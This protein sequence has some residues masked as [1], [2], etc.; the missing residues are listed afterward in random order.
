MFSSYRLTRVPHNPL[1]QAWSAADELA[2]SKLN[3]IN[4]ASRLIINE[5]FGALTTALSATQNQTIHYLNDSA[6]SLEAI[7]Q[8]LKANELPEQHQVE[9]N[10]LSGTFD[11]IILYP[12]K[13]IEYFKALLQLASRCLSPDGSLFIP[14]MVK[15]LAKG[16]I[17]A[18]NEF[19]AQVNPGRA[20]K[21]ARLV[22]IKQPLINKD[23]KSLS[24]TF[25]GMEVV[26]LPG[27]Y[28]AKALDQGARVF[29]KH[30]DM[31]DVSGSILDMGCGNGILSI[32]LLKRN[33]SA[34]LCL[35]DEHS[36][37]I[38]SAKLNIQHYFPAAHVDF[39]HSNGMNQLAEHKFNT[40][41]CNPPF[42]QENTVTEAISQKLFTDLA[43][44]LESK[45]V[46]WI[47]ANRHLDYRKKLLKLFRHVETPS[48]DAKF[49]LYR[50]RHD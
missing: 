29:I 47:I 3:E 50:C 31:I 25:D 46:C 39:Y 43:D 11:Q 45:G 26:G 24:Y 12:A 9:R 6:M 19:F 34:Q 32:A 42:H 22:E 15:H 48:K 44:S 14:V 49:T 18:M 28:G 27:C 7:A 33:P 17:S 16:H 41:L 2:F 38:A 5:P 20:V 37:A 4:T 8:N 10:K 23:V 21:K 30:F 35:V 40:I 36:Q 1:L 13:S